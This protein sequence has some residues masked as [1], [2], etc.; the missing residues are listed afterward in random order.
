MKLE[1]VGCCINQVRRVLDIVKLSEEKQNELMKAVLATLADAD[2]SKC[3]PEI[4][5]LIWADI[6]RFAGKEDVYGEVKS[7][8][9]AELMNTEGLVFDLLNKSGDRFMT[10]LKIALAGNLIDFAAFDAFDPSVLCA[11]IESAEESALTVDDSAAL[12]AGLKDAKKLLYIGDNCGEIAL[13]KF[14]IREIKAAFPELQVT[15]VTRGR[16]AIN[17]ITIADARQVK[18]DEVAAVIPNG[19]S[20][21]MGTVLSRVSEEFRAAWTAADLVIAKGQGNYESLFTE[22]E[23]RIFFLFMAKCHAVADP[24]GLERMSVVCMD[25]RRAIN[26][27]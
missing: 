14:F 8:F 22:K 24:L 23:K 17:D 6:V 26:K 15:F 7:R 21:V 13:D 16:P 11:K 10:A 27:K 1:C 9:N 2:F 20:A 18:M 5:A 4:M 12:R 3:T 19:D 25:N